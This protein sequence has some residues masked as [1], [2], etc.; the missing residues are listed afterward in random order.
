MFFFFFQVVTAVCC[1]S[2]GGGKSK[3]APEAKW[4]NVFLCKQGAQ[5]SVNV[6]VVF[7]KI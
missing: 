5:V 7:Q 6:M 1:V 2:A 4:I 3:N